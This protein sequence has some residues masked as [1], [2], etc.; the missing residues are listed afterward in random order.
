[1]T[2]PQQ[3]MTA[4][5][6]ARIDSWWKALAVLASAIAI[7]ITVGAALSGY[8]ALPA[9][10]QAN[11][12]RIGRLERTDEVAAAERE[13]IRDGIQQLTCLVLADRRGTP[14]EDCL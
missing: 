12:E 10:V 7:G 9:R 5:L 8:S 2:R 4:T 14:I 11:S 3:S 1:M 6:F 13:Q